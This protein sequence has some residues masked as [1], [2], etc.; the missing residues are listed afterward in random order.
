M[1]LSKYLIAFLSAMPFLLL[2]ITEATPSETNLPEPGLCWSMD[3]KVLLAGKINFGPVRAKVGVASDGNIYLGDRLGNI[4]AVSFSGEILWAEAPVACDITALA[5]DSAGRIYLACSDGTLHC[6]D[7][8][9]RHLLWSFHSGDP[10]WTTPLIGPS[11]EIYVI[12]DGGRLYCVNRDGQRQWEYRTGKVPAGAALAPDNSL[13]VAANDLLLAIDSSGK[14]MWSF[15]AK[16]FLQRPPVV[17]V[18][19]M[20][21]FGSETG[22][23]Y[24]LRSDGSEIWRFQMVGSLATAPFVSIDGKVYVG[25]SEG[26][27]YALEDGAEKWEVWLGNRSLWSSPLIL[28]EGLIIV[29]LANMNIVALDLSGNQVWQSQ[30]GAADLVVSQ[31]APKKIVAMGAFLTQLG[32]KP[33]SCSVEGTVFAADGQPIGGVRIRL[34]VKGLLIP[35]ST[36]TDEQGLF[37][38]TGLKPESYTLLADG[39]SYGSAT[40]KFTLSANERETF[41]L[42]LISD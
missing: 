19:G 41:H 3:P 35:N 27:L 1:R 2:T 17:S 15:A 22:A 28:S 26:Y 39:L 24:A 40:E 37:L 7:A 29:A 16:S 34:K 8:T 33:S 4:L 6:V 18:D 10:I 13:R 30:V 9:G 14:L 21:V 32:C 20:T 5:I 25:S 38:I 11:G 12:N 42:Y 36:L 31:G 23:I